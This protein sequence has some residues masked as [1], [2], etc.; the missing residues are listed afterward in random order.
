MGDSFGIML[1][2]NVIYFIEENEFEINNELETLLEDIQLDNP[3]FEQINQRINKIKKNAAHVIANVLDVHSFTKDIVILTP[4]TLRF[5]NNKLHLNISEE[6]ITYNPKITQEGLMEIGNTEIK[7][8]EITNLRDENHFF[9]LIE[10]FESSIVA[11]TEKQILGLDLVPTCMDSFKKV[12]K[13]MDLGQ[14]DLLS[15]A[16][17]T[18]KICE[19]FD[20]SNATGRL[21]LNLIGSIAQWERETI[22]ERTRDSLRYKKSKMEVYGPVPYGFIDVD[23]N[24][25]QVPE[26]MAVVDRILTDRQSKKRSYWAISRN[27]NA[28]GIKT[29]AGK[30][31]FPSSIRSI[32][33]NEIYVPFVGNSASVVQ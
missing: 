13:N 8:S 20:T 19:S 23:G 14:S 2:Q 21:M 12:E 25:E 9:E 24:L 29:R 10:E 32:A 33:I 11:P 28:E 26:E 6:D 17:S 22:A 30:P 27:L 31:W 3:D 4:Y 15:L 7:P 16:T 18:K 5:T 1:Q